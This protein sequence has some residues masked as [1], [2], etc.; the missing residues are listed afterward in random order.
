LGAERKFVTHDAWCRSVS[1]VNSLV[2]GTIQILPDVT[3]Q[4]DNSAL[5]SEGT[6][7]LDTTPDHRGAL[8]ITIDPTS[9]GV[10]GP[11]DEPAVGFT[12]SGMDADASG[13]VVF[14]D[15][16][17]TVTGSVASNGTYSANLSGLKAPCRRPLS[18]T[19][20]AA[21]STMPTNIA[22]YIRTKRRQLRNIAHRAGTMVTRSSAH[23]IASH[24]APVFVSAKASASV[25]CAAMST[26]SV[27][28]ASLAGHR[29]SNT[30]RRLRALIYA[31]AAS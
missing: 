24:R 30:P 20:V 10:L 11:A 7:V 29:P 15:G 5:L 21:C 16:T 31:S 19:T 9:K 26:R 12:A 28:V 13:V 1:G 27:N 18:T 22:R 4:A 14:T 17:N 6:F 3:D 23:G 8:A 2:D 25:F